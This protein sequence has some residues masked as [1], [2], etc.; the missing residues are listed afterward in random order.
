MTDAMH[1][2]KIGQTVDLITST[3]RSAASGRYQIIS[4]RPIDGGGDPQYRV[5]SKSE[6]HERVVS[7]SDLV[8]S[9]NPNFDD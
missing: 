5:K 8:S 1:K 4:L 7:E 6:S 9:A 2:F 3:A